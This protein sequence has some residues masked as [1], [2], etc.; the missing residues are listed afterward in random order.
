VKSKIR[1]TENQKDAL[2]GVLYYM[3]ASKYTTLSLERMGGE[4]RN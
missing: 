2:V 1:K 4:K 3:L